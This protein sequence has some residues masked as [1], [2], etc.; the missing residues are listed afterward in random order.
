MVLFVCLG[1]AALGLSLYTFAK[2]PE[3]DGH[4]MHEGDECRYTNSGSNQVSHVNSYDEEK[5]SDRTEAQVE[6]GAGIVLLLVSPLAYARVQH[7]NEKQR[8]RSMAAAAAERR[9]QQPLAPGGLPMQTAY[10]HQIARHAHGR[11]PA[12]APPPPPPPP[13]QPLRPVLHATTES[14]QLHHDT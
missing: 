3:C 13:P 6:L 9:S 12:A 8:R 11:A 5:A 2:G 7:L 1:L 4:T 10:A 14:A